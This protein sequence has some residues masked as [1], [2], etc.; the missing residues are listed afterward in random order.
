MCD[1][2]SD[3]RLSALSVHA[4]GALSVTS[5]SLTVVESDV[6][7]DFL[8]PSQFLFGS[9]LCAANITDEWSFDDV[10][11]LV[12]AQVTTG[13]EISSAIA[14]VWSGAAAVLGLFVSSEVG[15]VVELYSTMAALIRLLVVVGFDVAIQ[16]LFGTVC[17]DAAIHCTHVRLIT[18][19]CNFVL[20]QIMLVFESFLAKTA[21]VCSLAAMRGLVSRQV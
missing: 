9:A 12:L 10:Y 2:S 17:L 3:L 5:G 13:F 16:V 6:T 15:L 20:V 19:V 21:L 14:L 1:S 11:G 4:A 8:V 18:V 7:V